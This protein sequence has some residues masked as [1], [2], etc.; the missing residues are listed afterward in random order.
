MKPV[1]GV[2]FN[3]MPRVW[4]TVKPDSIGK[5]NRQWRGLT[6]PLHANGLTVKEN[7]EEE[8]LTAF[9]GVKC[10]PSEQKDWYGH[11]GKGQFSSF[12]RS[13]LNEAVGRRAPVPEAAQ[14]DF[15]AALLRAARPNRQIVKDL[16]ALAQWCAEDADARKAL[17]HVAAVARRRAAQLRPIARKGKAH[18]GERGRE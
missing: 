3:F 9:V 14:D 15:E 4:T 17:A 1:L 5:F 8:G 16:G 11:T 12:A 7:S 13:I 2:R 10:Y 18:G 6:N